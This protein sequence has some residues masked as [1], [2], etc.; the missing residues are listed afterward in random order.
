[1]KIIRNWIILIIVVFGISIALF[2]TGRLHNIYIENKEKDGYLPVKGVTYSLNG[3]KEKKIRENK[4]GMVEGKGRS[5][6]LVIKYKDENG[7]KREIVLGMT[8]DVIIFIPILIN[9]GENWI[10]EFDK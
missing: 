7:E 9:N 6:E 10:E 8:E 1:M 2:S 4:R 3:E 5:H